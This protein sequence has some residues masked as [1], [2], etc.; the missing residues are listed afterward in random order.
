MAE[1]YMEVLTAPLLPVVLTLGAYQAA[2]ALQK[3]LRSPL[4]NPILVG[5]L[6]VIVFL[7]ISGLSSGAYQ[8]GMRCTSWLTTPATVCLAIPMYEQYLVLKKNLGA[9]L[10]GVA[11]GAVSCLLMTLALC[12]LFA[13]PESLTLSLLPKSITSAIGAPLA[14]MNGGFYSIAASVI[15]ITGIVGSVL[16]STFCKMFRI[17]DPVAMGA[18][19][20]TASHVVGTAKASELDPLAGAVSSLAMVSA[21]VLTVA[22]Y[23]L[24]LALL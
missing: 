2:A 18:A 4:C 12:L 3:K 14:E 15:I 24:V 13:F 10:A 16:G 17:T 6:F 22:V 20:G 23:P 7:G 9:I 21:G 5:A 19:Y 8:A 1:I 11:A